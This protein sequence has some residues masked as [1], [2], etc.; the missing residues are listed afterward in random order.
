M[1]SCNSTSCHCQGPCG[2]LPAW[3]EGC[4]TAQT[5]SP[6]LRIFSLKHLHLRSGGGPDDRS[7]TPWVPAP[8]AARGPQSSPRHSLSLWG[9]NCLHLPFAFS[10]LLPFSCCF[11]HSSSCFWAEEASRQLRLTPRELVPSKMHPPQ[12]SWGHSS[13]T[14]SAFLVVMKHIRLGLDPEHSCGWGPGSG[15]S[16]AKFLRQAPLPMGFPR[17]EYWSGL[18]FPSPGNLPDSGVEPTSPALAGGLFTTEPPGK[19]WGYCHTSSKQWVHGRS[20]SKRT[21]PVTQQ[22]TAQGWETRKAAR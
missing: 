4:S 16:V 1:S 14:G 3:C 20:G 6:K 17:Q 8:G 19:G 7:V 12:R 21:T 2:S 10:S 15:G 9:D 18:S 22:K 5:P 11:L 13:H